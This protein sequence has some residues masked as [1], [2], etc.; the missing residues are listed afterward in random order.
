[1]WGNQHT[2]NLTCL[3]QHTQKTLAFNLTLGFYDCKPMLSPQWR[4][5]YVYSRLVNTGSLSQA[6]SISFSVQHFLNPLPS[7]LHKAC[8]LIQCRITNIGIQMKC[9]YIKIRTYIRVF[10]YCTKLTL[11]YIT[12]LKVILHANWVLQHVNNN[13][14]F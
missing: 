11:P 9:N 2:K 14:E 1:M 5:F 13:T 8:D 4:I 10:S 6:L 7:V 3:R 12:T